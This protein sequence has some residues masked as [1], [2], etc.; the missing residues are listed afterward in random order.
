MPN[1]YCTESD[2][3]NL[4]SSH[5]V[6]GFADHDGDGDADS[7]VVDRCIS[8]A[9]AEI[10]LFL[11]SRYEEAALADNRHLNRW[12][13]VMAARFLC[14]RRGN[15]PPESLELEFTRIVD[16]ETGFLARVRAGRLKLPGVRRKYNAAPSF[17]NLTVDRRYPREKIRVTEANSDGESTTRERDAASEVFIYE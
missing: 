5:G 10:D 16:P 7:G 12:A 8:E 1:T 17:S 9:S 15:M 3:I 13:T 14:L 4:L 6:V 11:L 2:L